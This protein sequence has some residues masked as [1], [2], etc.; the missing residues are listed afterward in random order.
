MRATTGRTLLPA[1]R[2]QRRNQHDAYDE[3]Q[4]V[5]PHWNNPPCF[6]LVDAWCRDADN[7]LQVPCGQVCRVQGV[8]LLRHRRIENEES[9]KDMS[10][11]RKV[12][13]K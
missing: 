6:P 4:S 8:N 7:L 5:Y 13:F 2:K 1:A 3:Q 12:F 9:M 10:G 11:F